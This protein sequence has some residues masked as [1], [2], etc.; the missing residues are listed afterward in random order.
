MARRASAVRTRRRQGRDSASAGCMRLRNA[1]V[2]FHGRLPWRAS[3][4]SIESGLSA[5]VSGAGP[6]RRIR[7]RPDAAWDRTRR[8]GPCGGA[9][10]PPERRTHGP[11]QDTGRPKR[12]QPAA[13]AG[14]RSTVDTCDAA[15]PRAQRR[16][17]DSRGPVSKPSSRRS[18]WPVSLE[19]RRARDRPQ[20]SDSFYGGAVARSS[21]TP[22]PLDGS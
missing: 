18:P 1:A 6:S 3:L 8:A 16:G 20:T 13:H 12:A 14:E 21:P 19:P 5:I 2:S 22:A 4:N 9:R 17:G 11:R 10:P 7:L 15:S